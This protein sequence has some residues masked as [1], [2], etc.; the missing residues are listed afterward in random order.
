MLLLTLTKKF[1]GLVN[2]GALARPKNS[3]VSIVAT[4]TAL[5]FTQLTSLFAERHHSQSTQCNLLLLAA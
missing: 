3:V 5:L 1:S 2:A 4:S